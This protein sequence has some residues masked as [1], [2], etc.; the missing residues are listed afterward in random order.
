MSIK[1]T[2][3]RFIPRLPYNKIITWPLFSEFVLHHNQFNT[4][5]DDIAQRYNV[6]YVD[7][8]AYFNHERKLFRDPIHYKQKGVQ[9]LAQSYSSF[10]IENK[11]VK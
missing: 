6:W 4:I 11:I 1:K 9:K 8:H 7:N 3:E 2:F 5:L 10:I